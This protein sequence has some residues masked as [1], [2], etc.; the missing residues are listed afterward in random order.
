MSSTNDFSNFIREIRA[1]NQEA[2]QELVRL[3][4][5]YLRRVIHIRLEMSRLRRVLDSVDVCQS[6]F[7]NFFARAAAGQFEL[8]TAAQLLKLLE[9]M[10]HNKLRNL[11]K[12]HQAQRR[13]QRR[14]T[15]EN[16]AAL[17]TL[18][19]RRPGPIQAAACNDLLEQA[20]QLLS[21]EELFLLDQRLL[22]LSWPEI[23][24]L[25][26]GSAEAFRK[27]LRRAL[28]RVAERLRL[29]EKIAE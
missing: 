15:A 27:Q 19:D 24:A 23:A 25:G 16:A 3:Y 18:V 5:P 26:G 7:A 21:D 11:A 28:G 4:E 14:Q 1:G 12:R 6:V 29:S 8:R 10:A 20:R 13:D 9:A 22:G 2:A 17:A